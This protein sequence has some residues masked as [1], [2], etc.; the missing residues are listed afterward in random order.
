MSTIILA[1][2]INS[3]NL[4]TPNYEYESDMEFKCEAS[5]DEPASNSPECVEWRGIA[6]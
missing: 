6:E 3:S 1:L 4:V 2:L 5:Y